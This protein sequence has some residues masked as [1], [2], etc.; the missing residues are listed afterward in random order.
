MSSSP[1]I[2]APPLKNEIQSTDNLV[3]GSYNGLINFFDL[4][5]PGATIGQAVPL[6]TSVIEKSHHDPV[7]DVFWISSK[8]GA[9][10]VEGEEDYCDQNV[11]QHL[12]MRTY[13]SDLVSGGWVQRLPS[14]AIV[15]GGAKHS[16]LMCV[17]GVAPAEKLRAD[18]Q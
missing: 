12:R 14:P 6:E 11:L 1:W 8:T 3:G 5:K 15:K 13:D 16:P 4:R 17:G 18:P 10:P 9:L 7:Y 2:L